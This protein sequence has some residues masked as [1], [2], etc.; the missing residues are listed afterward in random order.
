MKFG[1]FNHIIIFLKRLIITSIFLLFALNMFSADKIDDL[2]FTNTEITEVIKTISEA[3]EVTIVPDQDVK[4][5]I[6]RYFKDMTLEEVLTYLLEPLGYIYEIKDGVYFVKKKSLF[7]V[8]Y[9]PEKKIF[10]IS[11][12][13]GSVQD[14]IN[15]M[16]VKSK[17][18]IQFKGSHSDVINI[19][20]FDKNLNETLKLLTGSI[21]YDVKKDGNTYS[22]TKREEDFNINSQGTAKISVKGE[23]DNI[24]LKLF[25]QVSKDVILAL[26]AKYKK[27]LSL[28]SDKRVTIPYLDVENVSF[29]EL[30]D[31]IF[32]HTQQ[33]YAI[34]DDIYFVFDSLESRD[35]VKQRIVASYKFKNLN[36]KTFL[37]NVPTQIVPQNAYKLDQ[38][39]DEIIVFGSPDEVDHYITCIRNIDLQKGN[40]DYRFFKLKNVDVKKIKN[41]MPEKYNKLNL[42]IIDDQNMFAI[43][44]DEEN[45]NILNEYI[46]RIDITLKKEYKYKFKFLNPEDVL[47][48]M[49][50]K[51]V[52]KDQVFLNA[53]D[54]ALIFSITEQEKESLFAYFDSIDLPTPVIR[55]QLLI[56]EYSNMDD[57]K[58]DWGVG[59]KPDSGKNFFDF[60]DWNVAGGIFDGSDLINATFDIPT[61]FGHF[62]SANLA[63][64]LKKQKAR[65]QLSSEIYGLSGE[66]LNFVNTKTEQT[67]DEIIETD[68][69]VKKPVYTSTTYG[70]N[71]TVKGRATSSDE[72]YIEVT[73]KHS[74]KWGQ[75]EGGAPNTSEKSVK[76]TVRTK[77][78]KPIILG[79]FVSNRETITNKKIP[80][81]GDIPIIGNL[82]KTHDNSYSDTEFI[83]YLIP[84]IQKSNDD[85][86]KERMEY[87]EKIFSYYFES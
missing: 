75:T 10:T 26:F 48:A 55:Y 35:T 79:G 41:Y 70:L 83:I 34:I 67:R 44:M 16:M 62:F 23:D 20:I 45:Y 80:L 36:Y 4:G 50:P 31:I 30:L 43:Y 32:Q 56:V 21:D 9:N 82:F 28:L 51:T 42:T 85:L 77:T 57:F 13:G 46:N 11:S 24:Q 69:N 47:K 8:E 87:I 33:T 59:Y 29:N 19:H 7:T 58:F 81:L 38:E 3:F 12:N 6:T 68:T 14:I 53:N 15:E 76:N 84:F 1:F 64:N 61:V 40:F 2:S 54:A 49:L 74:D 71:I 66:T 73:A 65:I 25:N 27:K 60:D 78:G 52:Q 86:R 22:F 72:V 5:M 37:L 63:F 39:N 17:E 18:T